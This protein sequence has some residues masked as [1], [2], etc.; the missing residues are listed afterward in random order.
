MQRG[1]RPLGGIARRA[2]NFSI[3]TIAAQVAHVDGILAPGMRHH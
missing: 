2:V 1:L 3:D